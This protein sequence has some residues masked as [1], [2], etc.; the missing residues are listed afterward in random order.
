QIIAELPKNVRVLRAHRCGSDGLQSLLQFLIASRAAGRMPDA[1]LVD[2]D[3]GS[4]FGGTGQRADWDRVARE[5]EALQKLPLILAGGLTSEN[6][7][8][9]IAIVGPAGVDVATGVEREPGI[10]DPKRVAEFIAAATQGFASSGDT[11]IGSR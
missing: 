2:A 1:V 11:N 6:V 8:A 9:A 3:A 10:K 7:A 5:R 4:D